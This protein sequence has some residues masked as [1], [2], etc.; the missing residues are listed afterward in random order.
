MGKNPFIVLFF[1]VM[2]VGCAP[3][4]ES[5][6]T[7]ADDLRDNVYATASKVEEWATEP[8]KPP[9]TAKDVSNSYCYRALQD[10]L[11]Y[12]Q[13]MPGWETRLVAYQGT[14]APPPP[15]Y[16]MELLPQSAADA[17]AGVGVS[18]VAASKPVFSS[19]PAPKEKDKKNTS[20]QTTT[21]PPEIDADHEALPDPLRSH[22]L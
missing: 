15:A 13:P 22:Q 4:V 14:N 11:C 16:T 18:K 9:K 5:A 1:S 12:R 2:T 20:D 21:T 7:L 19:L 17:K 8:A 6:Q 3:A 10:I